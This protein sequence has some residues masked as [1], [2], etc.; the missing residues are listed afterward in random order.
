MKKIK[1]LKGHMLGLGVIL[2]TSILLGATTEAMSSE[3]IK[4]MVS[5]NISLKTEVDLIKAVTIKTNKYIYSGIQYNE[6]DLRE[7]SNVTED[8][9]NQ[10]LDGTNLKEL[11]PYYKEAEEKYGVNALFLIGITALESGWGTSDR[12]IYDNNYT[13]FGVYDDSSEGINSSTKRGNIL[14]TAKCLSEQY[15]SENGDYYNGYS[16]KEVNIKYCLDKN[17]NPDY[18][19]ST[20]INKIV[21]DLKSE[22]LVIRKNNYNKIHSAFL[23]TT[24]E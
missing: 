17:K 9:L 1:R 10:I 16:I 7:V 11:V 20:E 3:R 23:E 18:N 24:I 2:I 14:G 5:E 15:L 19:W 12:A 8:E 21:K 4:P 6:F 22:I 13:G